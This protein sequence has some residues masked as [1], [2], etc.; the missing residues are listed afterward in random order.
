MS[1]PFKCLDC[2]VEFDVNYE[3]CNELSTSPID[4]E[5]DISKKIKDIEELTN[6]NIKKN[7]CLNCLDKLIKERE[8]NNQLLSLEKESLANA[9]QNLMTE[10]ESN[11]FVGIINYSEDELNKKEEE[12]RIQLEG[13][14]E[15]EKS[16][17]EELKK[18]TE[19][20]KIL[21]EEEN[22]YW[23]QF[24]LLEKN[25]FLY[26]KSKSFT[27]NK[28]NLY[29]KEIK[30]FSNSN[31]FSD[32]FNISFIDKYGT[33]NGCRM[34]AVSGN[35]IL[36]DEI[37]SGWGYIVFLT[38]TLARKFNYDFKKYEMYPLGNSSKI[39]NKNSKVIYELS[40]SSNN[41]V[42]ERF[43][44]AMIIYLDCLREL[45]E[46][47]LANN[48]IAIKPTDFN[49]KI[50][51]DTI[52]TFNIRLDPNKPEEW[53]QCMKYLLTILKFLICCAL[54][55]ED[56]EYKEILEKASLLNSK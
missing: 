21:S 3:S 50:Q 38:T 13:L 12:V 11:E 55:R 40:L 47:L 16:C 32:L 33:I 35:S 19:E 43:N 2:G 34:G 4:Q 51:N 18:L 39:I 5:E 7:I 37:N 44:E 24:N 36:Y 41:K 49:Y 10:I 9:L 27:K 46:Y 53:S 42:L 17:E 45:N 25:I 1:L 20:L 54:K 31:I 15:K 28:I 14:Q 52:N 29:E 6:F 22:K 56:D 30:N 26:E 23:D 8:F 48:C